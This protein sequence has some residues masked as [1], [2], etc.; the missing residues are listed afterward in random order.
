[1]TV[2]P[3]PEL[4]SIPDAFK[5]LAALTISDPRLIFFTKEI[6][7]FIEVLHYQGQRAQ[8][9]AYDLKTL[10]ARMADLAHIAPLQ[11]QKQ[12]DK[13]SKPDTEHKEIKLDLDQVA[14]QT[15]RLVPPKIVHPKD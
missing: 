11:D 4:P 13:D 7:L 2:D 8:F 6:N 5:A 9:S 3:S 12:V 14:T 15:R 10:I 1:M